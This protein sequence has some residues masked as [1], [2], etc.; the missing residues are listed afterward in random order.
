MQHLGEE[1]RQGLLRRGEPDQG[2]HTGFGVL[3]RVL[4]RGGPAGPAAARRRVHRCV[5]E[6]VKQAGSASK[7]AILSCPCG[8][9]TGDFATEYAAAFSQEPGTYSTE[10]YD[11]AAVLLKGIDSGKITRPDLLDFVKNY[12]GQGVARK[13]QWT[14]TGELTT[15]LIWIYKVQ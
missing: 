13:Y 5:R 7:D 3:Q 12:E 10:G 14:E 11:L 8:P 1:G 15:T 4:R 9:A 2:R 6:F